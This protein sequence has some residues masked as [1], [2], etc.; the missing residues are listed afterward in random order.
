LVSAAFPSRPF[1]LREHVWLISQDVTNNR[2]L[3]GWQLWID[4]TAYSPTWS[5]GLA[6]R[7]MKLNGSFVHEYYGNG[8]DFVNGTNFLIASGQAYIPHNADGTKTLTIEA[9]A[10]FDLLGATSLSTS[11]GLP[12]IPRASQPSISS[13]TTRDLGTAITINTNRASTSFTHTLTYSYAGAT[14]TIATGVGASYAWT[15]PL[16]LAGQIPSATSATCTVTC[17]TYSGATLIGTK[18]MTMTLRVPTSVVPT[19]SSLTVSDQNASVVSIVGAFV[20]NLSVLRATVNAA[21]VY[22]STI[23]ASS[24][25]MSG[26]TI[27]SGGDIPA[28]ASGTVA[29]GAATTDSRARTGSWTGNVTVLAYEPPKFNVDPQVRRSTSGGVVA[30]ETGTSLRVDLNATVKS[31]VNTTERNNLTV[32]VFTRARGGS[33]WT[34]RNVIT[35]AALTYNSNFVVSGGAN[36]PISDAFEVQ[37]QVQ[38]KFTTAIAQVDVATGAVFMHWSSN[39]VGIGTYNIAGKALNVLGESL[40]E[41]G[42]EADSLLVNG[43]IEG[44]SLTIAD[45]G[46]Q[47]F[48]GTTAQRDAFF[49]SPSTDAARVALA[50]LR[51]LW[52]NTDLGWEESYYAVTGLT[53]LTVT[54]LVASTPSGWYPTREGALALQLSGTSQSMTSGQWYSNYD[55]FGTAESWR[56][57]G[58]SYFERPGATLDRVYFYLPG[59]Y[60]V[61]CQMYLPSGSGTGVGSLHVWSAPGTELD[62]DEQPVVLLSGFPQRRIFEVADCN[63]STNTSFANWKTDAATWTVRMEW[64]KVT[65][66]GPALATV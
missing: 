63:F 36:Y 26:T 30:P 2:S 24:W 1:N 14:G 16:T 29:L 41:G 47:P 58:N 19:I 44:D 5:N 64:L 25:S 45:I 39:G 57:H 49:G 13:P 62:L 34:A 38:D 4:K 15:P 27:A 33:V 50:N 9:A 23:S 46:I 55:A 48:R 56:T 51:P 59:R 42:V 12:T 65:Y 53:G 17:K 61:A 52:F 35:Q 66:L 6:A 43:P 7:W 21:G 18:T 8:Y 40:F 31:L 10:D 11:V 37:I 54:G 28:T 60:R 22:G 20:Q 3:M 32:R